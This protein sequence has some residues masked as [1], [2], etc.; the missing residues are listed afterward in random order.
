MYFKNVIIKYILMWGLSMLDSE[1]M[2]ELVEK[3]EEYM[4]VFG[5]FR[6]SL[7]KAASSKS[8]GGLLIFPAAM[9]ATIGTA[10]LAAALS[11]FA[12][13]GV[14][15]VGTLGYLV[16]PF[17]VPLYAKSRPNKSGIISNMNVFREVMKQSSKEL[18]KLDNKIQTARMNSNRELELECYWKKAHILDY[19]EYVGQNVWE[20]LDKL[21]EKSKGE[22]TDRICNAAYFVSCVKSA[23]TEMFDDVALAINTLEAGKDIQPSTSK[24]ITSN[25]LLDGQ[26]KKQMEREGKTV[27]AVQPVY[28]AVNRQRVAKSEP[29]IVN[30][31]ESV[32]YNNDSE[33][34]F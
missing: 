27:P 4:N 16:Q 9:T 13:F 2:I 23:V 10:I 33:M 26:I 29:E 20:K 32:K 17:T 24:G 30:T 5:K 3:T 21:S 8:W 15:G 25:L 7:Y 11:P 6:Y 18:A 14:L 31:K 28:H 19:V 34:T 22:N 1:K 12:F